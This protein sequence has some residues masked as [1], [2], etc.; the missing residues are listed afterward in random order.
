MR[1]AKR[2][3]RPAYAAAGNPASCG[4]TNSTLNQNTQ[5]NTQTGSV[6]AIA[7]KVVDSVGGSAGSVGPVCCRLGPP[8]P[9]YP[10]N[11][12]A[13]RRTAPLPR[14]GVSTGD[15]NARY[16]HF[17]APRVDHILREAD[18]DYGTEL[19]QLAATG[20]PPAGFSPRT[21]PPPGA[22]ALDVDAEGRVRE[23]ER[24]MRLRESC[25]Y[26]FR[27]CD[28]AFRALYKYSP[29]RDDAQERAAAAAHGAFVDE[30]RGTLVVTRHAYRAVVPKNYTTTD[31]YGHKFAGIGIGA[32]DVSERGFA[33]PLRYCRVAAV[34]AGSVARRP[35]LLDPKVS[36]CKV[37]GSVVVVSCVP[38]EAASLE[39]VV[40]C[41]DVGPAGNAGAFAAAA[42]RARPRRR[43]C[44]RR[45]GPPTTS[46]SS[47]RWRARARPRAP[48][49]SAKS[50][51]A[52]RPGRPLT[53]RRAPTGSDRWRDDPRARH[54]PRQRQRRLPDEEDQPCRLRARQHGRP[55]ARHRRPAI[56]GRRQEGRQGPRVA[57][58][59]GRQRRVGD[60]R[61][62]VHDADSRVQPRA[63]LLCAP[64]RRGSGEDGDARR[65]GAADD[66]ERR[67]PR[68]G[69]RRG[70]RRHPQSRRERR[71]RRRGGHGR[72]GFCRGARVRRRVRRPGVGADAPRPRLR[73]GPLRAAVAPVVRHREANRTALPTTMLGVQNAT[74]V[75]ANMPPQAP[76]GSGR[77]RTEVDPPTGRGTRTSSTQ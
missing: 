34:P 29:E 14:D 75:D 15:P 10:P 16:D 26:Q 32:H 71:A 53:G 65:G 59:L 37:E 23:R 58:V 2:R 25:Y 24:I 36:D 48:A 27:C 12:I 8:Q 38:T 40:A 45:T 42:A 7:K 18:F 74:P 47:R 73:A 57:R 44:P 70:R 30:A 72:R 49:S 33:V 11:E 20:P 67:R 31:Q 22:L 51:A 9:V 17:R 60:R 55:P 62:P 54:P 68:R 64:R 63:S 5:T 4:R 56:A 46:G 41:I 6:R 43:P 69:R 52:S 76:G 35:L 19:A 13:G 28:D 61:R 66:R 50:S 39:V 1:R 3:S 21:P 77:K